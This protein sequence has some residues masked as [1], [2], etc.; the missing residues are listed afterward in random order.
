MYI[1]LYYIYH[2]CIPI[3]IWYVSNH[4]LTHPYVLRHTLYKVL[5][6]LYLAR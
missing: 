3:V 1:I 6:F 2:I 4:Q 5:N